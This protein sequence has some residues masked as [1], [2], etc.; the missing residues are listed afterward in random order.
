MVANKF[1]NDF[2]KNGLW[3][4]LA[5]VGIGS[6]FIMNQPDTEYLVLEKPEPRNA[7]SGPFVI[8]CQGNRTKEEFRFRLP[9]EDFAIV[10]VNHRLR[11]STVERWEYI[12]PT[13]RPDPNWLQR[14]FLR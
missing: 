8:V 6:Y 12:E 3:V 10:R 11:S 1:V 9:S 14:L 13:E 2:L 5:V 7:E 4:A